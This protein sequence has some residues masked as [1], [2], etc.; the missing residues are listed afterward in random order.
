M[1]ETKIRRNISQPERLRTWTIRPLLINWSRYAWAVDPV[2]CPPL[3]EMQRKD[4]IHK[5]VLSGDYVSSSDKQER[6]RWERWSVCLLAGTHK[7]SLKWPLICGQYW[8]SSSLQ[9]ASNH[10][11]VWINGANWGSDRTN[12]HWLVSHIGHWILPTFQLKW[13]VHGVR[14]AN[15]QASPAA[16][17]GTL[18]D[19][20]N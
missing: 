6:E 12:S 2:A 8:R 7:E 16:Q 3:H 14:F 20:H 11:W 1:K 4:L 9:F 18:L 15:I 17:R 10:S 5:H 13:P 19:F